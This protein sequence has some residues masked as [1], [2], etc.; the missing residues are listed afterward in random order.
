M[1]QLCYSPLKVNRVLIV[2]SVYIALIYSN[3]RQILLRVNHYIRYGTDEI[4]L[5]SNWVDFPLTES[6]SVVI[7]V[8]AVHK[9]LSYIHCSHFIDLF[10]I[11]KQFKSQYLRSQYLNFIFFTFWYHLV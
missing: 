7:R 3:F 4:S 10:S 6:F 11:V 8:I 9:Y 5:M 2:V 1:E